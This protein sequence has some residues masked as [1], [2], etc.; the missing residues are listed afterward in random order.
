MIQIC[1]KEKEKVYQAIRS[2]HIDAAELSFP[3]LIDEIILT[4]KQQNLLSSLAQVLVDKRKENK[5]IPLDILL[6]FGI[7]AKLKQ[8]TSLID[9]PFA[10][11]DAELLAEL[12]WNLWDN[13]RSLSEGLFW[14]LI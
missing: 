6:T 13:E 12:G 2:G 1:H 9:V 7:A 8:K 10:I 11:S 3:N 4:M 5:H 14:G